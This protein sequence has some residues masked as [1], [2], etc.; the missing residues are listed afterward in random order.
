[1]PDKI[2]RPCSADVLSSA[3]DIQQ[4]E[5]A[6]HRLMPERDPTVEP[7]FFLASLSDDWTPRVVVVRRGDA[8]IGVVYG[9]ERRVGGFSTGIVYGDGRLGSLVV[10][11]AADREEIIIIAITSLFALANVRAVRLAIPPGDVEARAVGRAQR[12]VPFDLGYAVASPFDSHACLPLP[13]DY[14]KFL[15]VLGPKTRHN[16]RYYRRKCDAAGHAYV[17]GLSVQDL[18][19]AATDLR[20][21]S[22]I[23]IRR[24]AIERAMN[25]LMAADRPWAVGLRH[26]DGSWLS[27]A[28]GWFSG[29]RA[30]L[31]LQL[32]ND[33]DHDVAS[34]S[35]VL[36]AHLIETLIRNGTPELV[37]WSGCAAPLSRYTIPIPT[38]EVYLD[39]PA[40][41]WRLIRSMVGKTQPWMPR[42]IAADVRW[43]TGVELSPEPP[44]SLPRQRDVS[45]KF[46]PD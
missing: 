38:I 9:K 3:A 19:R 24:Q 11:E 12:L 20:A 15:R 41:G 28:G 34:L 6:V 13:D 22:R 16:F 25:V 2:G 23:P 10:A 17:H 39:T 5:D 21:K 45:P 29:H 30:I 46:L 26:R 40:L 36:R 31:F 32:N 27:V 18:Q 7:R 35:V 1:M 42:S 44:Q 37:F 4:L 33:R 8:I 14:Q 43:M